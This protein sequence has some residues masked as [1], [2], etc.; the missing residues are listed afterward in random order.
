MVDT[1]CP[2]VTGLV[3]TTSTPGPCRHERPPAEAQRW[4]RA[5]PCPRSSQPAGA[6]GSRGLLAYLRSGLLA[7]Q[8]T[9]HPTQLQRA[10]APEQ[11]A[12]SDAESNSRATLVPA[13]EMEHRHD[14]GVLHI[15]ERHDVVDALPRWPPEQNTADPF[16][17]PGALIHFRT[18]PQRSSQ[19]LS[20]L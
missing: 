12:A 18:L 3:P 11:R 20:P 7:L 15:V 6:R 1:A 2:T 4:A 10:N 8:L 16:G 14:V 13:A 9:Q 19:A 17:R 5:L